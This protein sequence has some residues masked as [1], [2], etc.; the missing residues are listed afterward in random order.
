M[1]KKYLSAF[2]SD[3]EAEVLKNFNI[4][5]TNLIISIENKI[6]FSLSFAALKHKYQKIEWKA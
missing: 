6:I 1:Y 5:S 2:L 4:L 3:N